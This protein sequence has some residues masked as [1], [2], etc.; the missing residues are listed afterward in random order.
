MY[1]HSYPAIRLQNTYFGDGVHLPC[2][3][4][5]PYNQVDANTF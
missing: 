2:G 3:I 1:D 5:H 4:T